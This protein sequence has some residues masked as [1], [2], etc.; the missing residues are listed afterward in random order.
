MTEREGDYTTVGEV[1]KP[2]II[3]SLAA[4][5]LYMAYRGYSLEYRNC[6]FYTCYDS[7]FDA[8]SFLVYE[9]L[10]F[11]VVAGV[12]VLSFVVALHIF[13]YIWNYKLIKRN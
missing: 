10:L 8:L 6:F 2:I 3:A 1:L 13:Y 11:I 5:V 9:L 7:L 12:L 4:V